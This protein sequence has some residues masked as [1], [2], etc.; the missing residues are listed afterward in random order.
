MQFFKA[1]GGLVPVSET[2]PLPVSGGFPI[3]AYDYISNTYTGANLTQTVY[4]RGGSGGTVV[5]TVTM[6]YDGSGNMLTAT[7]VG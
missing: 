6:T 7:F 2:N 4:K 1:G 5:G 3:P